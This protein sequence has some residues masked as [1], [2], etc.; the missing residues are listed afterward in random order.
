MCRGMK[1]IRLVYVF[2][3]LLWIIV[4]GLCFSEECLAEGK[5]CHLELSSLEPEP[6]MTEILTKVKFRYEFKYDEACHLQTIPTNTDPVIC[7]R[8][9]I[10]VRDSEL[11][12]QQLNIVTV[13]CVYRRPGHYYLSPLKFEMVS[14]D[15]SERQ[16]I[17]PEMRHMVIKGYSG[18]QDV[19]ASLENSLMLMPWRMRSIGIWGVFFGLAIL[20]CGVL[21][22]YFEYSKRVNAQRTES[23]ERLMPIQEFKT[24]VAELVNVTPI[25]LDEYKVYHDRLSFAIRLFISRRFGLDI[26]SLTTNQ[27][28]ARL[29]EEALPE[30][31]CQMMSELLKESDYV[32]YALDAPSPADNLMLLRDMDTLADNLEAFAVRK[33]EALAEAVKVEKGTRPTDCNVV[34]LRAKNGDDLKTE[35]A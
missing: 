26:M 30:S 34:F 24:E 12:T 4:C 18:T 28:V 11:T 29:K 32:K 23:E 21:F 9:H 22:A 5:I 20:F 15:M 2:Q 14:S 1:E 35:K 16:V 8:P 31:I 7:K 17:H 27:L 10:E 19:G 3:F 25:T 6:Q 33:E 13:E